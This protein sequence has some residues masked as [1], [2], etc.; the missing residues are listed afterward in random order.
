M[1]QDSHF[2]FNYVPLKYVAEMFGVGVDAIILESMI[3][4]INL[5]AVNQ[6]HKALS[7]APSSYRSGFSAHKHLLNYKYKYLGYKKA[8]MIPIISIGLLDMLAKDVLTERELFLLH[9]EGGYYLVGSINPLWRWTTPNFLINKFHPIAL[10]HVFILR[11]DLPTLKESLEKPQELEEGEEP[12][13]AG[14][15]T[16]QQ[17]RELIFF[18][19][20]ADKDEHEV[21][22]MKKDDVLAELRKIDPHLFMG[23]Q[24]HFFRLQKRIIFKSGRK[25]E[26]DD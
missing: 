24:K 18:A 2:V 17:Q 13:E 25:T 21:S 19:W 7:Y 10:D 23:D 9:P 14:K 16:K 1:I 20:L 26:N 4:T 12:A 22:L 15:L 6:S 11:S 5:Y 3:G 8:D